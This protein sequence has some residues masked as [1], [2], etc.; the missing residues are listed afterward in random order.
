MRRLLLIL[1]LALLA[2]PAQARSYY[3]HRIEVSAEVREDGSMHVREMREVIFS[4][5]YHAFDRNLPVPAGA[6]IENL[7]IAEKTERYQERH[8]SPRHLPR[9]PGGE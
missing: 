1:A 8:G 9:L 2:G 5:A 7:S 4:G 6:Q 3:L